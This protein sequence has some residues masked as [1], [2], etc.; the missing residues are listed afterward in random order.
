MN[1]LLAILVFSVII[2]VH[3]LGHFIV[4][5]INGVM[6]LEFCIGFGPKLIH[7]TKGETCYSIKL[8]PFGGACIM[9][10]EDDALDETANENGSTEDGEAVKVV[11]D[12]ERSFANKS[13][14]ARI[15]IVVAGP[16]FNFIL[17]FVF[18]IIIIGNVGYDPC[19]VD[20]V[21]E[22]SPGE[23]AG[24]QQG[25]VIDSING[26]GINFARE[27]NL[28][29]N[30][31]P[32]ENLELVYIRNGE[33][34]TTTVQ[35]EHRVKNVYQIGVS[36]TEGNLITFVHDDTPAKDAGL[37]IND[38]VVK[39][40]GREVTQNN[41]LSDL[42]TAG[43]GKLVELTVLRDGSEKQ[44]SLAPK[45]VEVEDYY[46]G[47]ACYGNRVMVSP[48]ETIKYGFGELGY[49][50]RYVFDSL[51]MLVRGQVGLDDMS[52][53]VGVVSIIGQVVEQSKPDGA[54]YVF[55]NM[56]NMTVL[57]STNLGVMNLL[58]LPAID[59]GRLVFLIIEAVRGKPVSKEKEGMVHMIGMILLMILMFVVMFNDIRKL[60]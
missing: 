18:A 5:K 9:L 14:W 17:A 28:Y 48:L 52:G 29:R 55:L 45:M 22:G 43:E 42:I 12:P 7:F 44:I 41:T 38:V 6:V 36:I 49:C 11:Y 37:K 8:I 2:I 24:L 1:I 16:L 23:T 25:D 60:F 50:V 39:V 10:G 53:P 30:L 40:D 4:A 56:L 51:G 34:F 46:S 54:F 3:E 57:I 27:F 31:Y 33:K 35:L 19:V 15:A 59:G 58:P 32:D 21:Y 26:R 13:V 47:F 20:V